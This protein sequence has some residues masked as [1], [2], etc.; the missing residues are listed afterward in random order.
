MP[1]SVFEQAVLVPTEF[2]VFDV[3]HVYAAD[4]DAG[5]VAKIH[6]RGLVAHANDAAS[7]DEMERAVHA[8]VDRLSTDHVQLARNLL[9]RSS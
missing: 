6:D 1:A 3:V 2:D 5:L 7:R 4:V 9:G 8:G